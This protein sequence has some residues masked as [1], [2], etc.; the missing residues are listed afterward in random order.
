MAAKVFGPRFE[1]VGVARPEVSARFK[2]PW[3]V[4]RT[5]SSRG[6]GSAS[7]FS[8]IGGRRPPW[9]SATYRLRDVNSAKP[10]EGE[11]PQAASCHQ[12]GVDGAG[13][14]HVIEDH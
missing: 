7:T 12:R 11:T 4:A 13:A 1:H 5:S 14:E 2:N 10:T 6:G 8:T 9:S 3:K